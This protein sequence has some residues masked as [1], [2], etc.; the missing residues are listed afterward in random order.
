MG[1]SLPIFCEL[2]NSGEVVYD[3]VSC[4]QASQAMDLTGSQMQ[5]MEEHVVEQASEP[6]DLTGSQMQAMEE[7][8]V[9]VEEEL[10]PAVGCDDIQPAEVCKNLIICEKF[11]G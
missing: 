3:L 5:S 7:H 11:C 1:F 2:S 4:M 6:M 8:V 10:I 9:E